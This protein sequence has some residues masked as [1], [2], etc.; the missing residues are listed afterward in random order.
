MFLGYGCFFDVDGED[1]FPLGLRNDLVCFQTL[2]VVPF[3][4][5]LEERYKAAV[6]LGRQRTG[7]VQPGCKFHWSL[8]SRMDVTWGLA[9]RKGDATGFPTQCMTLDRKRSFRWAYSLRPIETA[10][11]ILSRT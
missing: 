4:E 5:Y 8:S 1:L 3:E 10:V 11:H 2:S 6:G 7:R 9:R